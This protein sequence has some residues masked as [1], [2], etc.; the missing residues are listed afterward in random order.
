MSS[1][2]SVAKTWDEN[3]NRVAMAKLFAKEIDST[4]ALK[5]DDVLLDYGCGSGTCALELSSGVLDIIGVDS[6]KEMLEVF[7]KKCNNRYKLLKHNLEDGH[8]EE[9]I[10]K[11]IDVV[12]STMTLH[13][14]EKHLDVLKM[15]YEILESSGRIALCDLESEDGTFHNSNTSS[16]KHFGFD[17]EMLLD[18]LKSIGFSN[19]TYKRIKTIEKNSRSYYIFLITGYKS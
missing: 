18:A 16:V 13:H 3:P 6:S 19:L 15:L 5:K 1:F 7:A 9:L 10:D 14:I 4:I 8:F 2:D 12:I 11:K 17:V